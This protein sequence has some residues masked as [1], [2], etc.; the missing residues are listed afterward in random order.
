MH[1][2]LLIL[3][4]LAFIIAGTAWAEEEEA[5]AQGGA[6]WL[7]QKVETCAACHGEQGVSENPAFPTIAGQHESYL[8]HVL[9]AYR[10]GERENPV[11]ATQVTG[12][13]NAQMRALAKYYAQ[14]ESPLYTPILD[15]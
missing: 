10:D 3:S 14:Q 12:L 13:S 2:S 8:Y 15:R 6:D 4:F 5:G 1:R 11:M 7:Q 9:K